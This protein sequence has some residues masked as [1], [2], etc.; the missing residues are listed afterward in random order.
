MCSWQWEVVL[1]TGAGKLGQPEAGPD[2]VAVAVVLAG[3][4]KEEE[5][6]WLV[7]LLK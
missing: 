5:L 6:E 1:D 3:W 4:G 2:R 7:Y